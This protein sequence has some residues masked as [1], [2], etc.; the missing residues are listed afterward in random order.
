MTG[1]SCSRRFDVSQYETRETLPNIEPEYSDIVIPPNI[2]PMNFTIREKGKRF[3]VKIY[4]DSN[5]KIR[6]HSNSA[7]IDIPARTWRKILLN[8]KDKSIYFD[9]YTYHLKKWYK[10]KTITNHIAAEPIDRYLA[11]RFLRPNY[12]VLKEMMIR[13]RNLQSFSESIIMSTKTLA[14]CVNCHSF[15]QNDPST[16]LMHIRWGEAAGTLLAREGRISRI[17]TRTEFNSSPAAYPAWHPNGGIVAFSVNKVYQFYHAHGESRDVIDTSSDLILYD[18]E[19][20]TVNPDPKISSPDFMETY[21]NWSPDGRYLYFSRAPQLGA[22]FDLAKDYR[23]IK[24][25]IARVAFDAAAKKF[26]DA[27]SVISAAETDKSATHPRVSPDGRFLLFCMSEYG[28]FP[29]FRPDAD[30]FL[31]SLETQE[32]F[33]LNANSNGPEGFHSWSS[34][35]RWIVFT[36]KRDNPV[37]TRLYIAY[38]DKDGTGYKAFILPRKNPQDYDSI[39][40]AY[41]VPELIVKPVPWS[42]HQLLDAAFDPA[43]AQKA[44]MDKNY[45]IRPDTTELPDLKTTD[46]P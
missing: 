35:S 10:Y 6:I 45:S 29:V 30:L 41:S 11:Y 40:M 22:D 23:K 12:T 8:N 19:S 38:V 27:E 15:N 39:F 32:V 17:D 42:V 34:N 18:V 46:Y 28:N 36:S 13:Q 43:R 16:M 4:T 2:A 24:Y 14:G 5:E 33:R 21:P 26:G 37:F 9:I 44:R 25:D 7:I 1:L 31:L 3:L 20:N